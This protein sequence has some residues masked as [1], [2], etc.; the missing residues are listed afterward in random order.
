MGQM[1]NCPNNQGKIFSSSIC[2]NNVVCV[3]KKHDMI[4]DKVETLRRGQSDP[5]L[6]KDTK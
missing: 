6:Q 4:T 2:K 3:D 1:K 5:A